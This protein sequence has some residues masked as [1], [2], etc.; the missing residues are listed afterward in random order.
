MN[1]N[2]IFLLVAAIILVLSYLYKENKL[3]NELASD[4][5]PVPTICSLLGEIVNIKGPIKQNLPVGIRYSFD[6][7]IKLDKIFLVS[8]VNPYG[9]PCSEDMN[10]STIVTQYKT[11]VRESSII[12]MVKGV[13]IKVGD[14]IIGKAAYAEGYDPLLTTIEF[15]DE[16]S[17]EGDKGAEIV[18][19]NKQ[20]IDN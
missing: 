13:N 4:K 7:G 5:T 19:E 18:Q 15:P 16:G 1:K 17:E 6:I 10:K 20:K 9:H 12:P 14:K 3:T 11:P 8:P 2:K